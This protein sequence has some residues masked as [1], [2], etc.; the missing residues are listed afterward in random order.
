MA[1]RLMKLSLSLFLGVCLVSCESTPIQDINAKYLKVLKQRETEYRIK[2][3]DTV[4]MKFYNQDAELNQ[5]LLVL[6]DGHSDP[7]FM[8]DAVLAG[9]SI[10]EL[11]EDIGRY[12][13]QQV[14]NAEVSVQITPAGETIFLEGEVVKPATQPYTLKM[15]LMQ[16]MGNAGGYKLTA[17]LHTVILRRSYLDPVNV[18]VYRISLRDYY[19]T[20]PELL[21]LPNDHIIVER[22][23]V[24]LVRDYINEYVWGFLPPF[25]RTG[26]PGLAG[27]AVI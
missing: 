11:E 9:K 17:C 14:R 16:A 22:N 10:K 2:P 5:T 24:I 12:Y 4:N 18:D 6:P 19:D 8:D 15:T 3:G 13:A 25:L 20:H 27:A 1:E 21:L 23:W 7:F 26:L